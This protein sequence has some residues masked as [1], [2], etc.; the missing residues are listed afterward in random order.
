VRARLTRA[1]TSP[2][3]K[4]TYA[5]AWLS[6]DNGEYVVAPVGGS[7]SHLIA[8][9]AGANSFVVIPEETSELEAGTAVTVMMLERRHR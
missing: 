8:G 7:G 2:P 3:G 1:L 6:V 4:R 5:R 9:L